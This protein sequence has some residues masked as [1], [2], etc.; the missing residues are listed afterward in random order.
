MTQKLAVIEYR[1]N[2][3]YGPTFKDAYETL[4]K[5]YNPLDTA[6]FRLFSTWVTD[7]L[8]GPLTFESQLTHESFRKVVIG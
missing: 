3:I 8:W 2:R 5:R 1:Q 6:R 7:G 4:R